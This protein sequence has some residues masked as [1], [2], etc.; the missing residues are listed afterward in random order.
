MKERLLAELEYKSGQR[1]VV[2]IDDESTGMSFLSKRYCGKKKALQAVFD[3]NLLVGISAEAWDT[4]T[5]LVV[6]EGAP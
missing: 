3:W 2:A 4:K 1:Y 6:Q 5:G